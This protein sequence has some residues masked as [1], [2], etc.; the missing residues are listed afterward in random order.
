ML[1]VNISIKIN[2]P[3]IL[4]FNTVNILSLILILTLFNFRTK[5]LFKSNIIAFN[6]K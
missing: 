6:L 2:L 1:E 5:T 4:K 3:L